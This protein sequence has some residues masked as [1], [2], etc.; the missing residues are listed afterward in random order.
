MPAAWTM[1]LID[2]KQFQEVRVLQNVFHPIL[3]MEFQQFPPT[4][5]LRIPEFS[6]LLESNDE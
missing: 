3:A 5:S 4:R 6:Q 2:R 1:H